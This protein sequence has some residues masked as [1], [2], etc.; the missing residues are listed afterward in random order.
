M[1][2]INNYGYAVVDSDPNTI[3]TLQS[4]H[5]MRLAV[6]LDGTQ[7][8]KFVEGNSDGTKWAE[9]FTAINNPFNL[10]TWDIVENG[11]DLEFLFND[12]VKMRFKPDGV[13]EA[14]NFK[15]GV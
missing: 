5:K 12:V 9:I 3:P 13:I 2:H 14:S 15:L 8:W 4:N 6:S 1:A 10:T 7:I 11:D